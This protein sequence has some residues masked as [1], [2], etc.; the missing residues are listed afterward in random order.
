M[1]TSYPYNESELER[2]L[3]QPSEAA[4]ETFRTIEGDIAV[5]G[6]GGKMGPTLAMMLKKA[7]PD[8]RIYAVSRFSDKSIASRLERAGIVPIMADLLEPADHKQLP[9]V[10]NVYYLVGMKFGA[11]DRPPLTWAINSYLPGRMAYH[12]RNSRMVVFSTGNVYPFVHIGE[13]AP[14]EQSQPAPVGEYAQSCLGRERIF[15]YFSEKYDAPMTIVRLNY[16]NEPRY[17]IIAD[18]T[19]K[20][21]HDEPIDLCVPAVNLIWQRDAVEYILRSL[22]LAQ[23]PPAMLNVAG[24]DVVKVRELALQIACQL[25]KTAV[26]SL[27]EGTRSLLSDASLCMRYF[28]PPAMGLSEM[29]SAIVAWIAAGKEVLN[30][31]TKFEIQDGRF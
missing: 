24:P 27:A 4:I 12:Y 23:S 17:G 13:N 10:A 11:A 19:L 15:Q 29:V 31:P 5:L 20:I 28:G 3:S 9:D 8:K 1:N 30:K 26:F 2:M 25:G 22:V 18:L 14:S 6:A 7:A 16:A 21:L